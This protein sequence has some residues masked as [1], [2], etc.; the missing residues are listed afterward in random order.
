MNGKVVVKP[1]AIADLDYYY[2]YLHR[3]SANIELA[4]TFLKETHETFEQL[5][6]IPDTGHHRFFDDPELNNILCLRVSP[7]FKRYLIFYQK[8]RENY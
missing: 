4:E 5:A 7:K 3:R 2:K 6:D 8:G 1:Q